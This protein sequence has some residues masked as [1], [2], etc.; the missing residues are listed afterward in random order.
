LVIL[1]VDQVGQPVPG[2]CIELSGA[3]ETWEV[4]DNGAGDP[5]PDADPT[6]GTIELDDVEAGDYTLEVT[7]SPA[8]YAAP[9]ESLTVPPSERA[10]TELEL[11]AA[12]PPPTVTPAA[13]DMPDTGVGSAADSDGLTRLLV[14]L[15]VYGLAGIALALAW[16]RHR[17]SKER[18]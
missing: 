12:E 13:D 2:T 15:G 18:S 4:C 8:G 10:T 11:T 7:Q 5:A 1:V 6:E 9:P 14:L 16:Q 3:S 17:Q